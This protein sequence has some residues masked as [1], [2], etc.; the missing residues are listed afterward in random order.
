VRFLTDEERKKLIETCT[1]SQWK[2]L[3]ALVLL[4]ISTG[5]RRGELIHLKCSDVDLKANRATVRDTKNGD[6]RVL[7]LVGKALEALRDMK[8][9]RS[10]KSEYV[11][12][13]PSGFSGPY[14]HFDQHWYEALEA[15]EITDLRTSP[16]LTK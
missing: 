13:Q 16:K 8:L 2:P 12:P 1:N 4:A 7:P 11:F 14:E 10:A 9:Q 5:A 6:P 15:A 3:A